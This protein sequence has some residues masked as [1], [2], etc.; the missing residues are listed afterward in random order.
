MAMITIE[1]SAMRKMKTTAAEVAAAV[2][3]A[4]EVAAAEVSAS[5]VAA[6][7]Y[8]LLLSLHAVWPP[9]SLLRPPCLEQKKSISDDF[10][11]GV[12]GA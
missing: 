3:A 6:A 1:I 5:E 2:V 12:T 8:I 4:S 9:S 10:D 7:V 11:G